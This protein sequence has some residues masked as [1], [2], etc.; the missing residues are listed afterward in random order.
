V[1]DGPAPPH[2]I[3]LYAWARTIS[4]RYVL[5][6]GLR[7]DRFGYAQSNVEDEAEV[8]MCRALFDRL[9]RTSLTLRQGY[10]GI[11]MKPFG[12][13]LMLLVEGGFSFRMDDVLTKWLQ[14]RA[15]ARARLLITHQIWPL[16]W[17][18]AGGVS[19]LLKDLERKHGCGW[20]GDRIDIL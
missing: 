15:S 11:G 2:S 13:T 14:A 9:M 20:R 18:R 3:V 8:I 17:A 1:R 10:Y 6:A 7:D 16:S 5:S 4:A 19:R 12:R